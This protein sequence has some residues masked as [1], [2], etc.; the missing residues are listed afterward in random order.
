M[1]IRLSCLAIAAVVICCEAGSGFVRGVNLL[2]KHQHKKSASTSSWGAYYTA[3]N[4]DFNFWSE[5]WA[6]TKTQLV[7]LALLDGVNPVKRS[8]SDQ[9]SPA[10]IAEE[11]LRTASPT[12][13]LKMLKSSV[14]YG[15][16]R[17]ERLKSQE[18]KS[19]QRYNEQELGHKKRQAAIDERYHNKTLI[20]EFYQSNT[21]EESRQWGSWT[22]NRERQQDQF[23]AGTKLQQGAL[24]NA[25]L[26]IDA[27]E[28][29]SPPSSAQ[30]QE[31]QQG[32]KSFCHEAW[33]ELQKQQSALDNALP[34]VMI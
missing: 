19:L 32:M 17:I 20:E 11:K 30:L 23:L 14:E 31:A 13:K 7:R 2:K 28:K 24:K 29:S 21:K 33:A 12:I 26:L 18:Q 10:A 6:N 4:D 15:N 8:G 16:S 9:K 22:R 34:A 5:E 25:Q 1:S 27:Y 3:N